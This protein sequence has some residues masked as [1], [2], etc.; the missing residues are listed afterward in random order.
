[1]FFLQKMQLTQQYKNPPNWNIF[2]VTQQ[3][4]LLNR[5]KWYSDQN[6]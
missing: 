5:Y 2:W 3:F 4:D 6:I 1:M